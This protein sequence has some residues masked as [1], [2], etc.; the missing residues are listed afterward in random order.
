M[1]ETGLTPAACPAPGTVIHVSYDGKYAGYLLISDTQRKP[2][3]AAIAALK[4][5]G[6]ERIVMLTG[7]RKGNRRGDFKGA[8][9]RRIP[10]RTASCR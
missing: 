3:K 2:S 4:E 5:C 7:D 6:V 9:D 1:Q 8:F 10:R